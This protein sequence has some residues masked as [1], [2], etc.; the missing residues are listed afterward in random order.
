M[1]IF[2]RL[3]SENCNLAFGAF[4]CPAHHQT[5][6]LPYPCTLALAGL[7]LSFC[8]L[9]LGPWPHLILVWALI[10]ILFQPLPGFHLPCFHWAS[11]PLWASHLSPGFV[12][13]STQLSASCIPP[14]CLLPHH[15][16]IL[17][18]AGAGVCCYK[19]I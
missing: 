10:P 15:S 18:V 7:F 16:C 4:L 5:T 2:R 3:P 14:D 11:V 1:Y 12:S 6:S 19:Y 17:P 9:T 8:L 13:C